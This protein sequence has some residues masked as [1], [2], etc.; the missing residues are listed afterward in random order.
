MLP[1]CGLA[2]VFVAVAVCVASADTFLAT[3]TKVEGNKVTYK[4][5]TY[6][7]EGGP[8]TKYRYDEPVTVEVTKEV[9]I[10]QGHF[11]P[12][13]VRIPR[14]ATPV[15]GGLDN[16]YFKK[17]AERKMPARPCLISVAD[18][19]GD[20]GKITAINLWMSAYPK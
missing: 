5:T 4:K 10:T 20:K 16:P 13:D 11:L 1:R 18:K 7:A 8:P 19:D 14:D 3:I 17:L 12:D 6:P 9:A 2:V 15:E